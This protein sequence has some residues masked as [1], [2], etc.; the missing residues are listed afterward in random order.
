MSANPSILCAVVATSIMVGV[1]APVADSGTPISKVPGGCTPVETRAP[2]AAGQEPAFPGQTRA[3]TTPS[4]TTL[5]VTVV[6]TGLE[7]PWA[8]EPLPDGSLLV[9]ERPGRMR[10]VAAGGAV[11]APLEGLPPVSAKGQGGLLDVALSPDFATDRM[12]FWSYAEPRSG[13]RHVSRAR[14]ALARPA[15]R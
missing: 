7:H 9:T 1:L 10:I 5:N 13:K 15:P 6:A 12:I 14:R 8:V 4:A 3:C 11:G 2:N